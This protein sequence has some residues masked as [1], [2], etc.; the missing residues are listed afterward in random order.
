[1]QSLI[2][3]KHSDF[4]GGSFTLT[5]VGTIGK[6]KIEKMS[7]PPLLSPEVRVQLENERNK[8]S[9]CNCIVS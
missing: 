9:M 7:L 3:K 4:G 5:L 2:K 6:N 8:I 1:M